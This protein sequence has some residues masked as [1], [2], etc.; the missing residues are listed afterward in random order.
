MLF[1][2][3]GFLSVH[4]ADSFASFSALGCL[5]AYFSRDLLCFRKMSL[6]SSNL[7]TTT[8]PRKVMIEIDD[9]PNAIGGEK[10]VSFWQ[11]RN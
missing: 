2:S 6:T 11:N 10:A 7:K 5:F 1:L 9:D 8:D 3:R 4:V